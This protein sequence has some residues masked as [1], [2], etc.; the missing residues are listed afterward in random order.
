[1]CL[2]ENQSDIAARKINELVEVMLKLQDE[3]DV[4]DE[5]AKE[6]RK[7]YARHQVTVAG[8]LEHL[9][10]DAYLTPL[11]KVSV[12][13]KTSYALP[14]GLEN[15]KKFFE[16][17]KERG[18]FDDMA[19]INSNTYN[20]YVKEEFENALKKGEFLNIPGV[21]EAKVHRTIKLT[22]LKQGK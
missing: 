8:I 21:P 4:F 2:P 6:K 22:K 5:Q 18:V 11:A 13:E 14:A 15:K 16:Y 10:Q 3:A 9:G 19:T 20:G 7:E 17:L 1:M 12:S